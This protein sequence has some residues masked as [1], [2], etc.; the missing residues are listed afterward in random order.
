M[1]LLDDIFTVSMPDRVQEIHTLLEGAL[2]S[3]A[4]IRVHQ[5]KTQV[6]NQAGEKP[7]GCDEMQM[8][9][10]TAHETALVWRGSEA[11]HQGSRDPV[12]APRFRPSESGHADGR[13]PN[14]VAQDPSRRRHAIG[15][16]A[17][18]SLRGSQS[19]LLNRESGGARVSR[20]VWSET[21]RRL[22]EVSVRYPPDSCGSGGGGVVRGIH[23]HGFGRCRFEI[24]R[25]GEQTGSLVELGRLPPSD[26]SPASCSSR[27]VGC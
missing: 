12:G 18:G 14:V 4:G 10:V 19:Q 13:T 9:A 27:E 23:A 6:W 24:R 21:R 15:M 11:R 26:P 17:F 22:V 20:G 2:W 7:L 16:V 3:E 25:E 8:A 1:A 5:G